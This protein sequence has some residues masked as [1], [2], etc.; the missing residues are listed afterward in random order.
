M[1][2]VEAE[3][4]K[5]KNSRDRDEIERAIQDYKSFALQNASN[6]TMA[7]QYSAVVNKLKEICDRLPPPNLKKRAAGGSQG[8]QAKTATLSSEEKARISADWKKR[9]KK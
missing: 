3:V 5:Y 1:I 8:T 2:D 7:A 9:T 4:N 6:L